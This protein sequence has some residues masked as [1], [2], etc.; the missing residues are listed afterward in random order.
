MEDPNLPESHLLADEVNVDLD[1]LRA[2][3]VNGVC[4][5]VDS[6]DVVTINMWDPPVK[7]TFYLPSPRATSPPPA[8]VICL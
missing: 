4:C 3:M 2:P 7:S 1:V 8:V 5:H 6:T